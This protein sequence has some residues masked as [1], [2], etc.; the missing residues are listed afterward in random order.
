MK[1]CVLILIALYCL[2]ML[3]WG[4]DSVQVVLPQEEVT[5]QVT[6]PDTVPQL[7]K[8]QRIKTGVKQRI[9]NYLNEPYDTTRDGRYWWRAMK[10]GKI[11][12]NDT[13]MGYPKFLMFCYK[14]YKWGD[15]AFNSYDTA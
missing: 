14:T 5:Q 4:Q 2:P 1:R 9:D 8:W 13:T 10:H 12:F 11:D 6:D 3:S 15:R 7:N